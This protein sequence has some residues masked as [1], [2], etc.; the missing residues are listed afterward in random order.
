MLSNLL[1]LAQLYQQHDSGTPRER[2]LTFLF[3][4]AEAPDKKPLRRPGDV[5]HALR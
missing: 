2:G 1:E 5:L 3:G 4:F